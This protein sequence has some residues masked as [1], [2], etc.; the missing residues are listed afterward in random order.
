MVPVDGADLGQLGAVAAQL[1]ALVES[2]DR[3]A[4]RLGEGAVPVV[5]ARPV[6]PPI[7]ATPTAPAPVASAPVAPAAA[8][9]PSAAPLSE[10]R[11]LS[12]MFY[13]PAASG[14]PADEVD[15][16]DWPSPAQLDEFVARRQSE[17][18][19]PQ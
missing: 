17:Q 3:L 10:P 2:I 4:R 5:V 14:V 15:P 1:A 7:A 11:D 18:S 16:F 12:P 19:D 9:A 8:A 13:A 6:A